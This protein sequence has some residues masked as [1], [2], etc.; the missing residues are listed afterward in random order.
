MRRL[1]LHVDVN[2]AFLS[3]EAARRVSLGE[4]DIRLIPSA[5]DGARDKRT[6]IILA[7][8]IPAKRYGIKTGEPVAMAFRKCPNLLLASPDFR[9]YEQSSKAFMDIVRAY[10]P[11]VEKYSID[12]CFADCSGTEHIY[13]DPVTLAH[14]IKDRIREKLGFTV[15]VGVG[16][17]KLLAKMASDFEKPNRR[18][19][20]FWRSRTASRPGC[21]RTE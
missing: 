5:I 3:W 2:S 1:I 18:T 4:D 8:S 6:G 17:C 7:K 21:V 20:F 10:A 12:E 16:D 9:F 15:N 14:T 11:V 13:P 19:P